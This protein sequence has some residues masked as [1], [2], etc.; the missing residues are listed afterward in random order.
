MRASMTLVA[1]LIS[2][3]MSPD[4]L[5][6]AQGKAGAGAE[7]VDLL[8]QKNA[9][10]FSGGTC[11]SPLPLQTT[12]PAGDGAYSF[13]LARSQVQRLD[14]KGSICL[15]ATAAFPSGTRVWADAKNG[16]SSRLTFPDLNDW[17]PNLTF[18]A[19]GALAFSSAADVEPGCVPLEDEQNPGWSGVRQVPEPLHRV[20]FTVGGD[21]AWVE[22]NPARFGPEIL[23]DFAGEL[24]IEAQQLRCG[25]QILGL[26]PSEYSAVLPVGWTST[27]RVSAAGHL[28]PVSRGASCVNV[29]TPCPFSDGKLTPFVFRTGGQ[30]VSLTLDKPRPIRE[31]ILR[32]VVTSDVTLATVSVIDELGAVM[33]H[34]FPI[35]RSAWPSD[36]LY[37]VADIDGK[38][39][40]YPTPI[41]LRFTL[42]EPIVLATRIDVMLDSGIDEISEVSLFE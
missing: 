31:V 11:D 8:R 34:E 1:L 29:G 16:I 19:D 12:E 6:V 17:I 37:G 9:G 32:R 22:T 13:S 26:P 15:R 2:A 5:L 28:A 33:P 18:A 21:V 36:V 3:C 42:P 41:Y 25:K 40:A 23:E 7:R 14:S 4:D 10:F 39:I 38:Q 30:G 24:A 27:E 20:S 35:A